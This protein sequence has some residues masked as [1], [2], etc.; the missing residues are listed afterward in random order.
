[1][2]VT[3]EHHA[4]SVSLRTGYD[5]SEDALTDSLPNWG[6]DENLG[7]DIQDIYADFVYSNLLPK[8]NE[9]QINAILLLLKQTHLL[10]IVS[11]LSCHDNIKK[12]NTKM[13]QGLIIPPIL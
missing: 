3:T 7:C 13:E 4:N 2:F 10:S 8:K 9:I 12:P 6:P 5:L 1:M 11:L